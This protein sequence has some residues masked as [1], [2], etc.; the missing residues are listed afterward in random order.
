MFESDSDEVVKAPTDVKEDKKSAEEAARETS[1][2]GLLP[3]LSFGSV[4]RDEHLPQGAL[5]IPRL[6]ELALR[7]LAST[8]HEAPVIDFVGEKYAASLAEMLSDEVLEQ[9]MIAD[10]LLRICTHVH[11]DRFYK[12]L[13]EYWQP[14]RVY[15]LSDFGDS[16][17]RAFCE[18]Y[19]N[20]LISDFSAR[21]ADD[22]L[23]KPLII[24]RRRPVRVEEEQLAAE[25]ADNANQ[26]AFRFMERFMKGAAHRIFELRI[27]AVPAKLP[28]RRLLKHLR[29]VH[30]LSLT[31]LPRNVSF[32]TH[33]K[34]YG[35]TMREVKELAKALRQMPSLASLAVNESGLTDT[36]LSVL[37][38]E[39]LS[40]SN[41][42][43]KL[44]LSWNRLT[45]AS[46]KKLGEWL[47]HRPVLTKLVLKYNRLEDEGIDDFLVSLSSNGVL[48]CLDVTFNP[49]ISKHGEQQLENE[50]EK[51][52]EFG[53]FRNGF[54]LC[55]GSYGDDYV[56]DFKPSESAD[57]A[58]LYQRM[59][60]EQEWF[61]R[62]VEV[63]L[64]MHKPGPVDQLSVLD[65]NTS[66]LQKVSE[67]ESEELEERPN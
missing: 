34:E 57:S 2:K 9:C 45:S 24:D 44:E 16:H 19:A 50:I 15:E 65:S 63:A 7:A 12:R 56:V 23:E 53:I 59:R 46:W 54:R 55:L 60:R 17:K 8:F 28:L 62:N 40:K 14:T 4:A 6:D 3:K 67:L 20:H 1:T 42:L 38:E 37:I 30:H 10:N 5:P 32:E 47:K 43:T 18:L 29:W 27:A 48:E 64:R 52:V 21:T 66:A 49:G 39:G 33:S 22:F 41:T 61:K 51:L 58:L 35:V 13:L 26:E 11:H 36:M 31:F 25:K